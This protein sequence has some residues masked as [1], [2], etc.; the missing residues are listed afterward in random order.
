M[1]RPRKNN[2]EYFS[3]DATLRNDIK[4]KALRSNFGSDGYASYCILL[5]I[6]TYADNFRVPN[7]D[8]QRTLMA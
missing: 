3:H 4:I 5:E 8:L 6:L 1:A 7:S 2:A